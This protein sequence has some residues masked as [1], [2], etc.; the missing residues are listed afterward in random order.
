[1]N[2]NEHVYIDVGLV[3]R[4]KHFGTS[5]LKMEAICSSETL[6]STYNTARRYN[7]ED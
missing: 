6:V 2:E 7:P 1:M 3:S 5:A 4:H